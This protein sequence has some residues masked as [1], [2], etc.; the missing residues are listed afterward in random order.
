[1]F[2]SFLII[3]MTLY[4]LTGNVNK[5]T[6]TQSIIPNIERLDIDLPEIQEIDA[7]EVIRAKLLEAIKHKQAEFIVED[8]SL[9]F[10][11]LNGL[12]G[13]LI[14]WFMQTM[15][16]EGLYNIVK[17]FENNR[18]EAKTII[19]YAK[20]IDE[21]YYFEGSIKGE[22]VLPTGKF[23]FGWDQIFQPEAYSKSFAELTQEEKN[24]ISMRRIALN[25]LKE[26]L[27]K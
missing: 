7:R 1:M 16:N 2:L 9:Y 26:F 4:F 18:A 21:I 23:G 6:E 11:C 3:I 14:K 8:T 19:G 15:G 27:Q 5:F 20:N 10:D 24:D 13:P 22:I 12:P 25:K 17:K